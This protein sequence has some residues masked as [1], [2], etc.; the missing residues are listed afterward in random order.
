[1]KVQSPGAARAK[2]AARPWRAGPGCCYY[3]GHGTR[4]PSL[5]ATTLFDGPGVS[6]VP[7]TGPGTRHWRADSGPP[8]SRPGR[9]ESLATVTIPGWSDEPDPSPP[10][11]RARPGTLQSDAL[12]LLSLS[13]V[14]VTRRTP[15]HSPS[16]QD[17]KFSSSTSTSWG[18]RQDS[19][20][21]ESAR[22][23]GPAAQQRRRPAWRPA[24][25]E[26]A[27]PSPPPALPREDGGL[28]ARGTSS[29]PPSD[30]LALSCRVWLSWQLAAGRPARRP[31]AK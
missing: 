16:D 18:G 22:A 12:K 28:A 1:M 8:P 14:T 7:V 6:T 30:A 23:G 10:W 4:P 5:G 24:R 26:R 25:R 9:S 15:S 11:A 19:T 13:T 31:A 21:S 29:E 20:S 27:R 3:V 17:F 2:A